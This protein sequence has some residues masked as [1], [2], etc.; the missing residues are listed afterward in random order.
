MEILQF[1]D[2]YF[3]EPGKADVIMHGLSL[4]KKL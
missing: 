4:I 1:R 3:S 2:Q